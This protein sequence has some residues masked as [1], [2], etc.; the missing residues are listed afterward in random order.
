MGTRSFIHVYR[1]SLSSQPRDRTLFLYNIC[2]TTSVVIVLLL[3][4]LVPVS[5]IAVGK[6]GRRLEKVDIE[7]IVSNDFQC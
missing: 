3:Q 5:H 2:E 4:R 7:I 6:L 1:F